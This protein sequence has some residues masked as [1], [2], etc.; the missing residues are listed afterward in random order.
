MTIEN[1]NRESTHLGNGVS[2]GFTYDFRILD[3]DD[4]GVY[5]RN[6]AGVVTKQTKTTHYTVSGVG[7]PAGTVI[8]VTAPLATDVV[9]LVLE[10]TFTQT[11]S[12]PEGGAFPSA[13]HETV[14]DR[15]TNM[16][17]HV[18]YLVGRAMRLPDGESD[19]EGAYDANGN[20]ITNL[21]NASADS[22]AMNKSSV[23]AAIAA[24]QMALN[25]GV[26]VGSGSD[27]L[28]ATL[29]YQLA[30]TGAEN[31]R[32]TDRM[33]DVLNVKDFGATGD[34]TTDDATDIQ[35]AIDALEARGGGILY[36]PPGV[37]I[38]S[39]ALT[40]QKPILMLGA[41]RGEDSAAANPAAA[42]STIRAQAASALA[43]VVRFQS[44]TANQYLYGV[45]LE[46]L[47][48]DGNN[49]AV[50]GIEVNSCSEAV[51]RNV[52]AYRATGIGI[53]LSDANGVPCMRPVLDNVQAHSGAN[54]A[55]VNMVGIVFD[56]AVS[57][58][59]GVVQAYGTR[60][61]TASAC[62]P[63]LPDW[64]ATTGSRTASAV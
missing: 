53:Y 27:Y 60:I 5:I 38:V 25:E 24:A 47:L 62:A 34:G 22:D 1:D 58:G 59:Q 20:K 3:E 31:R 39:A 41:G 48:I 37:Y 16:A 51:L 19:G 33:G 18:L 40:V 57:G 8:F 23:D 43:Y 50:N 21:G 28:F 9:V 12:Y 55:A 13:T 54:V 49:T 17:K 61:V 6:A 35:Q 2:V 10:P 52:Y 4:L 15:L 29:A 30:D 26:I 36:F 64:P 63:V 11:A 56:D 44:A 42:V 32:L 45:G 46:N 7:N 14:V